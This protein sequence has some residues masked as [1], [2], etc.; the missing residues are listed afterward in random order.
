MKGNSKSR[1][2]KGKV[3]TNDYSVLEN[4]SPRMGGVRGECSP[5]SVYQVLLDSGRGRTVRYRR[6]REASKKEASEAVE[7]LLQ[8][9]G[10][11]V[12]VRSLCGVVSPHTLHQ[13][14]QFRTPLSLESFR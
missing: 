14:N 12:H 7:Y 2:C 10:D 3:I 1:N 6:G 4:V 5:G 11:L 8:L 9:R 13:V